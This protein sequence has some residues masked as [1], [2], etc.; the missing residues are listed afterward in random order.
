MKSIRIN[1]PN[2]EKIIQNLWMRNLQ[3]DPEWHF[4]YEDSYMLVRC[5]DAYYNLVCCSLDVLG[6]PYQAQGDWVDNI[7]ATR[8]HQAVYA[9][10]FHAF[11]E[12]AM[13]TDPAEMHDTVDRVIHCFMNNIRSSARQAEPLIPRGFEEGMWEPIIVVVNA[14]MRSQALGYWTGRSYNQNRGY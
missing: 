13:R 11:S 8:R 7:P 10:L 14:L 12:L 2:D 4:F 5:G 1:K 6:I 9:G 3:W